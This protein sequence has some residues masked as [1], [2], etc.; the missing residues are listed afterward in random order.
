M[1]NYFIE[2]RALRVNLR[3]RNTRVKHLFKKGP[4]RPPAKTRLMI[5]AM[6]AYE[7][8]QAVEAKMQDIIRAVESNQPIEAS[9]D[10]ERIKARLRTAITRM[11]KKQVRLNTD[12]YEEAIKKYR[13]AL[14]VLNTAR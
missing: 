1:N 2:G 4:A 13:A 5:R 7:D 11:Q 14:D 3:A 10:V 9:D 6:Q 8:G 12:I